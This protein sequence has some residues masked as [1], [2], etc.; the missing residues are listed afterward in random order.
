MALKVDR[1][2]GQNYAENIVGNTLLFDSGT[3]TTPS[4]TGTAVLDNSIS[5]V[6]SNSLRLRNN[7]PL[8]DLVASNGEQSTI[9]EDSSYQLSWYA[10]K[11]MGTDDIDADVL[12]YEDEVLLDTQSF[13]LTDD[14]VWVRFQSDQTYTFTKGSVIT[15]QFKLKSSDTTELTSNIH[16]DGMMV[17]KADRLNTIVPF[18]TKPE[19]ITTQVFGSYN[20]QDDLTSAT[21]TTV[22]DTWYTIENNAL[23]ALTSTLG[24]YSSITPYDALANTFVL[25]GL[26]LYDELEIRIDLTITTVTSNQQ[27]DF[28][29]NIAGGAAT[30]NLFSKEYDSA[31][32]DEQVTI[33]VPIGVLTPLAKASGFVLECLSDKIG[34]IIGTNGYYMK[35]NKRFI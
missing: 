31:V 29:L 23:G 27:V 25:A 11:D 8:I 32:T 35:V 4:G 18:Y 9:V 21:T 33:Y 24:G 22:P 7:T 1:I 3:W 14:S 28:R 10:Y 30:L 15:F 19:G 6:G 20:Y 26:D 2:N 34:A 17:N 16:F 5:F 12:I 13:T